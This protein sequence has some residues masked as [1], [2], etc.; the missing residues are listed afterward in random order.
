MI[1]FIPSVTFNQN[2]KP[3]TLLKSEKGQG[4]IEYLIIVAL[5]AVAAMGIMRVM[6]QTVEAK[7]AR[8][9]EAL[10]GQKS[11]TEIHVET[12]QES[13]LKKKDMSDFFHG[14]RAQGDQ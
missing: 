10:Q 8:V 11:A 14:T 12:I 13:H 5:I 3:K 7:F 2:R 1:E 9:T 6:S 4:L